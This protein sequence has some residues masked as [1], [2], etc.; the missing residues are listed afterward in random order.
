MLQLLRIIQHESTPINEARAAMRAAHSVLARPD[1]ERLRDTYQMQVVWAGVAAEVREMQ[2]QT[3][4]FAE[5]LSSANPD[6]GVR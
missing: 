1:N 6:S 3:E 4:K 2:R 5:S